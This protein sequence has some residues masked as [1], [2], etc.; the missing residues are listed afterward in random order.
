MAERS[1]AREVQQ[2][3]L[4]AGAEFRDEA[5][6]AITE[7]LLQCGVAGCQGVHID[8]LVDAGNRLAGRP[9]AAFWMRRP[10]RVE[11]KD[12]QGAALRTV[13]SLAAE[14]TEA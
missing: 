3:C 9:D 12:E 5:T 10:R 6:L 11:Q 13:D 7:V 4:G 14:R 2:L 8:H 1:L